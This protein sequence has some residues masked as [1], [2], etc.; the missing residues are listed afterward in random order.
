MDGS[1]RTAI[2]TTK[3]Y[4]PNGLAIDLI[5]ERIYFADAHLDYI[6][7]CDYWGRMRTVLI[8]NDLAM[9]HPHSL[10]LFEDQLFW[11]DRGHRQLIRTSRFNTRNKTTMLDVS[12]QALSVKVAHSTLQPIEDSPCL[13]ANCEHLCLLSPTV[14]VGYTCSC[15][16]GYLPDSTNPNRCNIDQTEFL[17]VLNDNIMGGLKIY[18]NDTVQSDEATL[19]P[20]QID[21]TNKDSPSSETPLSQ[22]EAVLAGLARDSGFIWSRMVPVNDI[23]FGYDFTYDF[24]DQYIYWLQHSPATYAIHILRVK[25]DGENREVFMSGNGE[26]EEAFSSPMC[27]E[28]DPFARNLIVGHLVDSHIEVINVDNRQ[29]TSLYSNSQNETGVGHPLMIT[30]N[31]IDNEIYWIDDGLDI[32]PKKVQSKFT[33]FILLL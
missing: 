31:T 15:Q 10:S 1:N 3:I 25:F 19:N 32:V 23:T 5:R 14:S 13:R 16:I 17:M 24:R 22:G 6:E 20:S 12:V 28:F 21:P 9:H 11:L 29:R 8:S 7:S 26:Q 33:F 18:S 4:W 2:I 27:L 30:L